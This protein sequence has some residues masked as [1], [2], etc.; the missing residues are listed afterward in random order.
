MHW[1]LKLDRTIVTNYLI[2]SAFESASVESSEIID[3]IE[4]LM[5]ARGAKSDRG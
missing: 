3:A 5:A 2:E 1:I 4:R